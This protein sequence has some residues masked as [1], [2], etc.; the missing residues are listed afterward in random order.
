[1]VT[2]GRV[3]HLQL[4]DMLKGKT[5]QQ[6]AGVCGDCRYKELGY[7]GTAGTRSWGMWGLQAPDVVPEGGAG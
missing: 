5:Q 2:E 7:V 4:G 1:V 3:S 6:G